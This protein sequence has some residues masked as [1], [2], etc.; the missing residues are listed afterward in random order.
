MGQSALA[1]PL[2]PAEIT[3]LEAISTS[4]QIA[5]RIQKRARII[6][7]AA[8][9]KANVEIAKELNIGRAYI[10]AWRKRFTEKGI[11]GLGDGEGITPE[12]IVWGT[13]TDYAIMNEAYNHRPSSFAHASAT[14]SYGCTVR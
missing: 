14:N 6:L 8:N 2:S 13:Q 11:R 7:L 10:A 1:L 3:I 5:K 9:G 4:K 12:P